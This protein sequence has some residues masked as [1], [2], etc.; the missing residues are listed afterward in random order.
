MSQLIVLYDACVLYP[1]PLCDLLLQLA[2]TGTFQAR[3]SDAI[4]EEWIR[5]VKKNRPEISDS[6][7]ARKRRAMDAAVKDAL[8]TN[9]EPIIPSLELPDP[10]DLHVLAA[11]IA[12]HADV[13]VTYNLKDFPND[14]LAPWGIQAQH[15][16][17][18]IVNLLELYP[19]A[20][21]RAI[22]IV[23][24]RLKNPPMTLN[25]YLANLESLS[26]TET[27][28]TLRN[29]TSDLTESDST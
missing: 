21:C 1:M 15:P 10:D 8:V 17:Q 28:A 22:K 20:V 9:Y 29:Y 7:I 18:F 14:I 24:T 13:I 11:A 4:H 6:M 27:A 19:S 26:L 12:G 2:L 23:R 3:W 16:D 5:A 25:D